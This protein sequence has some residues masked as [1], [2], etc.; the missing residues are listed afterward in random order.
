MAGIEIDG[1]DA[2]NKCGKFSFTPNTENTFATVKLTGLKPDSYVCGTLGYG[3]INLKTGYALDGPIHFEGSANSKGELTVD[4]VARIDSVSGGVPGLDPGAGFNLRGDGK[5]DLVPVVGR[6]RSTDEKV[7]SNFCNVHINNIDCWIKK[8][9]TKTTNDNSNPYSTNHIKVDC[10]VIKKANGKYKLIY[11]LPDGEAELA[12]T[13]LV[14]D[15][16]HFNIPGGSK[17]ESGNADK[18]TFVKGNGLIKFN[19]IDVTAGNGEKTIKYDKQIFKVSFTDDAKTEFSNDFTSDIAPKKIIFDDVVINNKTIHDLDYKVGCDNNNYYPSS[20]QVTAI[21][22][23]Y[24]EEAPQT[25]NISGELQKYLDGHSQIIATANYK[26]ADDN[27]KQAYDKAITDGKAVYDKLSSTPEQVKQAAEQIKT[28]LEAL[29]GDKKAQAI[30][31]QLST[32]T[33]KIASLQGDLEK[34]KQQNTT[35]KSKIDELTG[36]ISTL[37]GQLEQL[38]QD[39]TKSVEEKQ[40]EITKLNSQIEDLNKQVAQLTKDKESLQQQLNKVTENL[41]N[42]TAQLEQAKK[43][44][45]KADEANQQAIA[46]LNGQITQLNKDK[47]DLQGQIDNKTQQI[48]TLNKQIEQVKQDKTKGEQEKQKEIEKLNG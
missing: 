20:F 10:D 47:Q 12:L 41:S 37:N 5:E 2:A 13:P 15:S 26:N 42:V 24:S 14:G 43:D 32:A 18:V 40:K 6:D 30:K 48:S 3:S 29:N 7:S 38:K 9:D 46:I 25:D 1:A 8:N 23:F 19:L 27:L 4:A 44:K 45:Q 39:N 36:K 28:T 31:E 22:H 35:D 17:Q 33:Q 11:T 21:P 34:A 16:W